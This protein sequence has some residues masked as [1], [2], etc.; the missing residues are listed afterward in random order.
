LNPYAQA[1]ITRLHGRA[2]SYRQSGPSAEHTADLLDE[3]A[4]CIATLLGDLHAYEV[5]FK[6]IA[7]DEAAPSAPPGRTGEREALTRLRFLANSYD[8]GDDTIVIERAIEARAA[9]TPSVGDAG[10]EW[11]PIETAPKDGETVLL[12][13]PHWTTARTGWRFADDA[14]QDCQKDS[15]ARP[16]TLWMPLPAAPPPEPAGGE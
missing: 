10:G 7:E 1:I 4:G 15:Y 16:P 8:F 11:R 2:E 13:A 14:W 5:T 12:W 6:R 3:A 9:L